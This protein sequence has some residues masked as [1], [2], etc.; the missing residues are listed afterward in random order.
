MEVK[1]IRKTAIY[2]GINESLYFTSAKLI[3][4][5]TFI[6]YVLTNNALTSETVFI[7]T[8]LLK[9]ITIEIILVSNLFT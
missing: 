1:V 6:T 7:K 9:N 4:F 3:I 5:F 8:S 2:R